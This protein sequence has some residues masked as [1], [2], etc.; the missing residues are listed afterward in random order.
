MS[1]KRII[2]YSIT[3]SNS[4]EFLTFNSIV[5]TSTKRDIQKIIEHVKLNQIESYI[6][7]DI[8]FINKD[9]IGIMFLHFGNE[10]D[11]ICA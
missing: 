9:D 3:K 2:R 4:K 6:V 1:N 8:L 7:N 10:Y 11:F 5:A